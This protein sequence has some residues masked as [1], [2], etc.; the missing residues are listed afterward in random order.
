MCFSFWPAAVS[1]SLHPR[2]I[3]HKSLQGLSQVAIVNY[4][5]ADEDL[6]SMDL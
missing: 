5:A 4:G 3:I 2:L 1:C 6:A